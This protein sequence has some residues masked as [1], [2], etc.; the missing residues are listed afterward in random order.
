MA[1]VSFFLLMRFH[2]HKF[3]SMAKEELQSNK[4]LWSNDLGTHKHEPTRFI[5]IN[6]FYPPPKGAPCFNEELISKLQ[7]IQEEKKKEFKEIYRNAI[8]LKYCQKNYT[9]PHLFCIKFKQKE[10]NFV[11]L[12]FQKVCNTEHII[13]KPVYLLS[14]LETEKIVKHVNNTFMLLIMLRVCKAIFS[15]Q[16]ESKLY[17]K[18]RLLSQIN[19]GYHVL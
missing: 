19:I 14:W 2:W 13:C 16:Y 9:Q 8:R 15:C 7:F 18:I 17:Q 12:F 11:P 6:P 1:Y 3:N 5:I 4:C 10:V